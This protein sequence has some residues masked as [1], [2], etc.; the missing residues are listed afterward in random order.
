MATGAY[1]TEQVEGVER[2]FV[3]IGL[4]IELSV[5]QWMGSSLGTGQGKVGFGTATYP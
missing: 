2:V 5:S 3:R 4:G 1:S